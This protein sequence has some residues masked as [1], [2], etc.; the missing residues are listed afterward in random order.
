MH[1]ANN[2]AQRPTL[3]SGLAAELVRAIVQ[4]TCVEVIK[5]I[6]VYSFQADVPGSDRVYCKNTEWLEKAFGKV[7]VANSAVTAQSSMAARP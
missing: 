1:K 4:C 3:C 6:T 5:R 7:V 2:C